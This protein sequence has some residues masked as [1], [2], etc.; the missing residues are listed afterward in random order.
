[1]VPLAPKLGYARVTMGIRHRWGRVWQ[2]MNQWQRDAGRYFA[3]LLVMALATAGCRSSKTPP[4]AQGTA[5]AAATGEA[6]QTELMLTANGPKGLP[7]GTVVT[8]ERLQRSFPNHLSWTSE[9]VFDN[10][11]DHP[12]SVWCLGEAKT[13]CQLRLHT[14]EGQLSQAVAL[15]RDVAGPD[16]IRVGDRY[17]SIAKQLRDCRVR[18]G[19]ESGVECTAVAAKEVRVVLLS[20]V[21][22]NETATSETPT[23]AQ[24]ADA[25]VAELQW[26][27]PSQ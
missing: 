12:V 14:E 18:L 24:L 17:A 25:K 20:Q 21:I 23:E 2:S 13:A 5:P 4:D 9:H 19:D 6:G 26:S 22:L 10:A 3:P 16:G 27:R 8:A 1:M 7:G 15:H 11:P